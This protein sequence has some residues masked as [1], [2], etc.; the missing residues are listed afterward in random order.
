MTTTDS[1]AGVRIAR[2]PVYGTRG[3]VVS[4]H[5][6]ASIA[7]LRALERGGTVVDAF[8]ATSAALSVVLPQATSLGGDAFILYRDGKVRKTIGLNASGHAPKQATPDKFPK[9]MVARGALAPSVPG[10]IRGWERMHEKYGK[11]PFASLLEPA[12]D[13]AERGHPLSRVLAAG[14][15]LFEAE[16][17]ADPGCAALYMPG[18]R[19]MKAGEIVRQPAL[20]ASL[21]QIA[22]SGAK[23]YYE[24]PIAA[25]I[26]AYCAK[27]GGLLS[28]ED[29]RGYEPEWVEPLSTLYRGLKVS[30]MPPNSY[31]VLMLLQL[32]ALS[33]IDGNDLAADDARRLGYLITAMRAAFAEGQHHIAD[34]RIKP[35]PIAK[36]L[37][38]ETTRKLQQSV[39]DGTARA[40]V[41]GRGGTSCIAIADGDGN[42][43][44]VVQSVFHV[45]GAAFLDPG[46]GIL[47]NNRMMGF[48][49]DPAHASVVAP[50]KRPSHTLNPVVVEAGDRVKYLMATPG[51]PSQTMTLVQILT[52][53]VD[54]GIELTAAI[55]APR[56]SLDLKGETLIEEA[57]PAELV[58]RLAAIGHKAKHA[59][60]SSYFGSVKAIEVLPNGVLAGAAD[61][62]REAF[63]VGA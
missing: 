9:G 39:R 33:G 11:L 22:E 14:L 49:T 28:A 31:G 61:S 15:D 44:T 10:M 30:V 50:G 23:A 6:L 51:G 19:K 4:G 55:E 43:I 48:T 27:N 42:A 1:F 29:F 12:I 54:R 46:T 21:R 3:M 20:A 63:A 25:S 13:I 7:G 18:G 40:K 8:I 16:V 58:A 59:S 17:K 26:G 2:S 53:L 62:R 5:S 57:Y 60:G 37:S 38:E 56:W 52:N 45:F 35:A 34:P 32:N 47:M 24:G 36:L 41:A